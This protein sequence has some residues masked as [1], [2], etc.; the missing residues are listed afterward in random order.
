MR[1]S[2]YYK[3]DK[4]Q[5]FLDFVDV[6]LETDVAVFLDPTAIKQ[7]NSTWGHELASLLQTFFETVLESIK[8]GDHDKAKAL[9]ASLN[10][11]NEFHLGFS[12]GKSQGHG[13]GELS[14]E[15]L[16]ESL[17]N[18][19]ASVTGVLQDLEDTALMIPG[20]ATDMI[21]DAVCNIIRGALIKYT[22]D[23]CEYYGIPLVEG[24]DSGPIWNPRKRGWDQ[25]LVALPMTPYGK[26][27]LVPKII[28]RHKLSYDADEYYRH[29]ILPAMQSEHIRMM[30][31]LVHLLKK[32]GSP[33]VYK[34]DLIEKYGKDKQAIAKQTEDRPEVLA[35]YK[36]VKAKAKNRPLTTKQIAKIEKEDEPDFDE[37]IYRLKSINSGKAEAGAYEDVIEE[38]FSAIFYPYLCSP[39]KQSEIHDGRKR[40]DITY[41]NEAKEGFFSWVSLHYPSAMIFV[42]CKNYGKDVANPEIDQ[43]AGRFSLNRGK[44]GILVCR[45]IQDKSRMIKR[46]KDTANDDRGFIIFLDDE[47][48]I[49]L[50]EAFQKEA[51]AKRFDLLEK[52]FEELIT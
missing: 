1:V 29:Y 30:S 3:L 27:I 40:I 11:G 26:L 42:E 36:S 34:K 39:T 31:P 47:D 24:V 41:T 50:I 43:L 25:E 18:S 37:L 44:V 7:L 5:A 35:K 6:P 49:Q 32:D 8:D 52:K 38:I 21:S 23:M 16:W 10:E 22:Q 19:K 12:K 17:T 33:R 46:C 4:N 15:S 14:A 13:F 20:I 45:S 48:V 51:P 9:L 2:D 28:V